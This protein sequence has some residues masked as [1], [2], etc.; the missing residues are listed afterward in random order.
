MR[1]SWSVFALLIGTICSMHCSQKRT[2]ELVV[3]EITLTSPSFSN[4]GEIPQK[5]TC[6]GEDI[7]PK[8]MWHN[9]PE[10]V[11]SFVLICEDPDAPKGTWVHWVVFNLKADVRELPEG[12][13]ITRYSGAVE[14]RNSWGKNKY[15]GPCP[16]T[17][18]HRY[19][20]KLYALNVDIPLHDS[21]TKRDVEEEMAGHIIAQGTLMRTYKRSE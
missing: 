12:A 8:L 7:S 17:G 21:A 13:E 18:S 19:Y 20:F 14:G 4:N 9:V 5:F 11:R 1:Q 2:K 15:G 10:E 16:P 3:K 6:D